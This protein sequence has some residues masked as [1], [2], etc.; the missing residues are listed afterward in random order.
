[1][2]TRSCLALCLLCACGPV[3]L[4]S[5]DPVGTESTVLLLAP[6]PDPDAGAVAA[7]DAGTIDAGP[8]DAGP[9][10]FP[11]DVHAVLQKHCAG[12][13]AGE[14]YAPML[15]TRDQFLGPAYATVGMSVGQFASQRMTPGSTSPMPPYGTSALPS[16]DEVATVTAWVAAGMPAGSCGD[17]TG[18]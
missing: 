8:V 14:T 18:H 11:C 5:N 6:Q 7:V 3:P 17:L 13:H 1:M 4:E 10:G 12:C 16:A 15:M 2:N 9:T